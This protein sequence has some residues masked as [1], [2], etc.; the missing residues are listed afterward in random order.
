MAPNMTKV[1]M[2]NID[3]NQTSLVLEGRLHDVW[4]TFKQSLCPFWILKFLDPN[5][6][7]C[8][9]KTAETFSKS[10]ILCSAEE[11]KSFELGTT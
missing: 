1:Y 5:D 6:F 10:F 3:T 4:I 2:A 8:M 7:Y 11:I 9:E